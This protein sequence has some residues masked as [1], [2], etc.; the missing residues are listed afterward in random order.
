VVEFM[1]HETT[2]TSQVYCETLKTLRRAIQNKKRGRLTYRIVLLH[3]N[4][5]PHTPARTRAQLQHFNFE[6]FDYLL[7]VLISLQA[8]TTCLPTCRTG[9]DH[10]A[11]TTTRSCWKL[12]KRE[13]AH[14]QQPSLTQA[15]KNLFSNTSASISAVTTLRSSLSMCV[16]LIIFSHCLFC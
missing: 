1:Q 7:T 12:L 3:D 5:R 15:Y 4:V 8:T 13:R 11:S 16:F 9:W 14:R 6:L 10:R 2:I